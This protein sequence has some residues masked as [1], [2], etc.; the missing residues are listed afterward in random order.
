[1]SESNTNDT[2]ER[3]QEVAQTVA[4]MLPPGTAFILLAFD[5]GGGGRMEYVS[6]ASRPDVVRGM[7]EFIAKSKASF[8]KHERDELLAGTCTYTIT[9]ADRLKILSALAWRYSASPSASAEFV[10]L[11]NIF[12][13]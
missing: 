4:V 7:E 5:F 2:R 11:A 8:G 12:H 3:L 9:E 1:M 10:R 6:N 13:G